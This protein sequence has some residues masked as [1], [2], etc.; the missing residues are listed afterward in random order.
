M[1]KIT[2]TYG[3]RFAIGYVIFNV[4]QMKRTEARIITALQD[5]LDIGTDEKLQDMDTPNA[6]FSFE[7][8][9]THAQFLLDQIDGH[10]KEGDMPPIFARYVLRLEDDL[11]KA[12]EHKES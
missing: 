5:S 11:K 7:C 6:E 12:I 1:L 8:D 3:A 2:T 9:G 4:K 10:F